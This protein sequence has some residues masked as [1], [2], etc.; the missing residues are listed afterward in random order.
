MRIDPAVVAVSTPSVP[1]PHDGGETVPAST[2]AS[3]DMREA[4]G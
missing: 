3:E 4:F 2:S 1:H